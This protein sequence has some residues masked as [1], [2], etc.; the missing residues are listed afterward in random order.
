MCGIAGCISLGGRPADRSRLEAMIGTLSHR[1]PD[2][3]GTFVDGPAGLAAARLSIIDIAGG[4]QPISI[5]GDGVTVAQNGEIYNYVEL[6]ESLIRSGRALMTASD[7]EVIGHLYAAEGVASLIRGTMALPHAYGRL[8]FGEDLELTFRTLAGTGRNPN[9][10]ACIV[11][12]IEPKWTDRI[13]KEIAKTGKPVAGFHIERYG[14]LKTI[15]RASRKAKFLRR[16]EARVN[17]ASGA[18]RR[19]RGGVHRT[20][21][22]LQIWTVGTAPIGTLVPVETE[23]PQ[24]VEHAIDERRF[25]T[26]SVGILDAQHEAPAPRASGEVAEQGGPRVAEMQVTGRAGR[27][28]RDGQRIGHDAS[29]YRMPSRRPRGT[30]P[31]RRGPR[32]RGARPAR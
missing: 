29:S 14:D 19:D 24:V 4:H 21:F 1:G 20:T 27:E 6:R 12:G 11:I 7:T 18:E 16:A 23:P 10:A 28:P 3:R 9:I 13:V 26:S 32:A 30:A 25:V 31:P 5:A 8:Q 15:E 22:A 17:V 2:D